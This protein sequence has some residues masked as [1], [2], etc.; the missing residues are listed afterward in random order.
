[1]KKYLTLAGTLP[2]R[3]VYRFPQEGFCHVKISDVS[4]RRRARVM[5][6]KKIKINLLRYDI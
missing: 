1:M 2:Y 3:I 5:F 4:E 6:V